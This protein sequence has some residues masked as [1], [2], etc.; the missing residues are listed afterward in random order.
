MDLSAII[1]VAM[2]TAA[3]FGFVLWAAFHSRKSTSE[4]ISVG[5]SEIKVSEIR[6]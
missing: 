3:F 2:L 5:S 1:V 4:K 6:K